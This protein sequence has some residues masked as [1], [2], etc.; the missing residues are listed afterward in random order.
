MIHIA[1][2]NTCAKSDTGVFLWILEISK[3]IF[4]TEHLQATAPDNNPGYH[5]NFDG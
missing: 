2:V 5:R 1:P 4:F 3:N